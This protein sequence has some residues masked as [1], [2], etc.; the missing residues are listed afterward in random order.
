MTSRDDIPSGYH[1]IK[2]KVTDIDDNTP[3]NGVS[4]ENLRSHRGTTTNASGEFVIGVQNGDQL[5]FTFIGRTP[6]TMIFLGQSF[7]PVSLAKADGALSEVIVTGFQNLD[8]KKFS[9]A[10][11]SLKPLM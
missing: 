11:T 5:E 8:K 7:L 10:A 6:K 4:I 3:L 9:G 1:N 2:G